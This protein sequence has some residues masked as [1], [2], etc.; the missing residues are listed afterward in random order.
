MRT[1]GAEGDESSEHPCFG[2][3]LIF[4]FLLLGVQSFVEF[5]RFVNEVEGD[6]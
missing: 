3:T 1:V 6:G 4:E 2:W 5:I